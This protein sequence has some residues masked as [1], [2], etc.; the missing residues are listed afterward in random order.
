LVATNFE[1]ARGFVRHNWKSKNFNYEDN[2]LLEESSEEEYGE[3]EGEGAGEEG[4]EYGSEYYDEE[5]E[6]GATE[7]AYD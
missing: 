5:G 2:P 4:S 1:K 3:E 6:E 7:E